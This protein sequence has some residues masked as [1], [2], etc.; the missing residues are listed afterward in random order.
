MVNALDRINVQNNP[1]NFVDPWGL[2]NTGTH[3]L[4]V[5]DPA[6]IEGGGGFA[7]AAAGIG[8]GLSLKELWNENTEDKTERH[9]E[10]VK[11]D[12]DD[13]IDKE[14]EIRNDPTWGPDQKRPK[15]TQQRIKDKMW[16]DAQDYLDNKDDKC[17]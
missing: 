2:I 12:L 7:G 16:E 13:L 9:K 15:R 4:R 8:L 1:V 5:I 6:R 14:T 3:P 11:G 10:Q 17:Q